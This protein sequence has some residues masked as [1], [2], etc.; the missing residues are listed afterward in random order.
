MASNLKAFS[1]RSS[2]LALEDLVEASITGLSQGAAAAGFRHNFYNAAL[3][4]SGQHP[5]GFGQEVSVSLLSGGTASRLLVI[6][7][8]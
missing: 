5:V 1:A 6:H 4:G 2:K 3:I 7:Q 8:E